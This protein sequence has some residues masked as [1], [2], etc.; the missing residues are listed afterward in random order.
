MGHKKFNYR[1]GGSVMI[2]IDNLTIEEL[3]EMYSFGVR[4]VVNDGFIVG[5]I[6]ED[7]DEIK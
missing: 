4:I 1:N 6:K 7:T 2:N 5:L 3:N